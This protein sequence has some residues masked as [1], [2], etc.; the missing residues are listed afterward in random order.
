MA[1]ATLTLPSP[2]AE[3]VTAIPS[4]EEVYRLHVADVTRWAARLGGPR[5]ELEDAVQE[6]FALVQRELPRFRGEAK[7][8]TWLYRITENVVRHQ[9]RRRRFLGFFGKDDDPPEQVSPDRTPLEDVEARQSRELLYRALDRLN[10]RYRT[11]LILFEI[12]DLPGEEVA[13]RMGIKLNNLW[14]L[15]HRARADLTR[16]VAELT[17]GAR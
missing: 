7:L 8:T 11:A 13:E 5:V 3:A 1:A 2:Q 12:E 15:L 10:E 6:V 9:R 16:R 4:V 14:V 17:E